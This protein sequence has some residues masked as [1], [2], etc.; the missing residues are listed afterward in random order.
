MHRTGTLLVAA[1]AL[2]W[3]S[4]A[5]IA[6]LVTTDPWTTT[7]LRCFFSSAFLTLAI[8][9]T[10]GRGPIA[11]W[12]SVGWPGL[13]IAICLATASTCFILSLSRTSVANTLILMSVG[14]WVAG[15]LGWLVLGERVPTRTW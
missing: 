2:C 11:Q 12:R 14:P 10:T 6:R 9:I 8:A 4:G 13:V 5:L 3:S 7:T 15:A 1:A